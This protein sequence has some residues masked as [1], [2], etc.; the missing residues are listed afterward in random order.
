[1]QELPSLLQ[2]EQTFA[3][4]KQQRVVYELLEAQGG[5]AVVETLRQ[6]ANCSAGV[7]TAMAKRGL[8]EVRDESVARD[9]FADR[10]GVAPPPAPSAAQRDAIAAILRGVP[11]QTFLLHGIT[12]SG[13]TLVY[14][15]VLRAVL[16][17]GQTAIVLVPEI[18]LTSQTVDRFRGA[19]GDDV[20]VLHSGLSDGERHDAWQSLRRGERRIAVGA[21]SALF[22]P[23]EQVGVVI[24]DEEHESSYKQSETPRYHAREAAIVRARRGAVVV[25]QCHAKPE[26][27]AP[28]AAGDPADA[29][30]RCGRPAARRSSICVPSRGRGGA[31]PTHHS[32]RRYAESRSARRRVGWCAAAESAAVAEA[33]P[34]QCHACGDA[35][36]SAC[37]IVTYHRARALVVTTASKAAVLAL[38]A[39]CGDALRRKGR[40]RSR[41]SD[42]W[43]DSRAR[44]RMDVDTTSGSID[45][46]ILDRVGWGEIDIL[47]GTQMIAKGLLRMTLVGVID[48]DIGQ[49]LIS[50]GRA[51]FQL[52]SL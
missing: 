39:H 41:S 32:I 5:W 35:G 50:G 25:R 37:S 52:L 1:V 47:L 15:E 29:A 9:P 48:A 24:V 33:T 28:S 21:R 4:A 27:G 38:C 11:G 8:V 42:S 26:L 19:F 43:P 30:D 2:R 46:A 14:I 16:A 23:I 49:S 22:A 13:K 31:L 34:Q 36:V 17:P 51:S 45:T 18:A 20:A 10:P 12:G 44:M 40:A 6:Q 3:R 7:I